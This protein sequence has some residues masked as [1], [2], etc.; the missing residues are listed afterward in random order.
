MKLSIP[1][2]MRTIF[3]LPVLAYCLVRIYFYR[4]EAEKKVR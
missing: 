2:W 1:P 3:R 4:R